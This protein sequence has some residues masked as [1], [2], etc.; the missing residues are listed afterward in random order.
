[1]SISSTGDLQ[2][3]THTSLAQNAQSITA[4]EDGGWVVTWQ[5]ANQ[6][7]SD[8]GVYMQAFNADGS[9][10]GDETL[11]NTVTQG[12]QYSPKITT[13]SDGGWVIVWHNGSGLTQQRFDSDGDAVGASSI[14]ASTY[15]NSFQ[16]AALPG[17]GWVVVMQ[18]STDGSGTSVNQSVFDENGDLQ[19][20]PELVN[21]YTI[22]GQFNPS[23]T[24][25]SDG[26][27]VVTWLSSD[28]EGSD[29]ETYQ[30]A[31]NPNGSKQGVETRVNSYVIGHQSAHRVVALDN[32][33]W[34]TTW[35]SAGQDGSSGGVYQQ[36]FNSDGSPNGA[37]ERVNTS[38]LY[39]QY[40]A[41]ICA[42]QDGGWV[43][44]W[45]DDYNYEI[46][47][48]AYAANGQPVG[49]ETHVNTSTQSEQSNA[50]VTALEDGGWVVVW[51]S[52]HAG[53]E[54]YQQAYHAD[55]TE[56]GAETLINTFTANDQSDPKVVA[57]SD[58]GWV[59]TWTS[60]GQDGSSTGVFQKVFNSVTN[61]APEGTD[62]TVTINEDGSH[63]FS[64]AD[65]GFTD[66]NG[67]GLRSIIISNLPENG[68]LKL[69]G[70]D[71]TDDQEIAYADISK[72]VWTPVA[73]AEGAGLASL[74]FQVVDNGGTSGGG[75][76]ADQSANTITFNVT[77]V[78]D[79]PVSAITIG[80]QTATEDT[81][82]TLTLDA[83]TFTDVDAGDT[84]TYQAHWLEDGYYQTQLPSWLQFDSVTRTFSGTPL[85]YDAG[86]IIVRVRATDGSGA[87]TY[88]DFTLTV[89]GVNDAPTV[90]QPISE[91]TAAEDNYFVL[92]SL[93]EY[94]RDEETYYGSLSLSA[95]LAN[96]DSLPS[97]L[98]FNGSHL[99]GT[100]PADAVGTYSI[101]ITA[102][103]PGGKS[104]T[105]TFTLDVG[106]T[107]DAPS[108]QDKILTIIESSTYTFEVADFGFSDI[109]NNAFQAIQITSYPNYGTLMLDGETVSYGA[110]I[111]VSDF[112]K[113]VWH[114]DANSFGDSLTAFGFKVIDDGGT[115][116]GGVN[117]DQSTNWI[118]F[119]VAGTPDAPTLSARGVLLAEDQAYTFSPSDFSGFNDVDGDGKGFITF[120]DIP[121]D[122]RLLLFGQKVQE[123]QQIAAT[124]N[125][126]S[127]LKWY[128]KPDTTGDAA[129]VLKFT[130]SDN[131][132]SALVSNEASMAFYYSN[133]EDAPYARND[134]LTINEG[135]VLIDVLANDT[136]GDGD[137]LAIAN[138]EVFSGDA[139]VVIEDG[140]IKLT[141]TGRDLDAGEKQTVIV[142]YEV[143][144]GSRFDTALAVI[145]VNGIREDGDDIGGTSVAEILTGSDV[146]EFIFAL[147]GN[148]TIIG[149]DGDDVI[150][151]GIG[152]D[153][154]SGGEGA[155]TFYFGK[156]SGK[157]IILDFGFDSEI[158]VIDL[159][160]IKQ[161][162]SYKDLTKNHLAFKNGDAIITIDK[163]NTIT[164]DDVVKTDLSDDNFL[165]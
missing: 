159:S 24:V 140:D 27:W 136:D 54:F 165:F 56:H 164:L 49:S 69:D 126:M 88:Q 115:A 76:N 8:L 70:I 87:S 39:S 89:G 4:L 125:N 63:T 57:L 30:Q 155:D 147:G 109:E 15:Y 121:S 31:Y 48:Q 118:S 23:V 120:T 46:Y 43:I 3:N 96:G 93:S 28:Q 25:L 92:Y 150:D 84:L 128:A 139:S 160:D 33:G 103:D 138:A 64:A 13:L 117:K 131:S 19:G 98:T 127:N 148:D 72:L 94:F 152:N 133:V 107:N 104:I 73:N 80:S 134:K 144:D 35:V 26:G 41:S 130:I 146:E 112:A 157:D 61:V 11:V 38:T 78:N 161:I 105:Q 71:V 156:K 75:I 119:D 52:Y 91:Q 111:S 22:S 114:A 83:G 81:A 9:E 5:S 51:R 18:S 82:F 34:V 99:Y 68:T 123:G 162:T 149:N 16:V 86:S 67:D 85:N 50:T 42:L 74:Q 142:S 7:G 62:N 1:M 37:E 132:T 113:L 158:D 110:I 95:E 36:L 32:G 153:V 47:Q 135:T 108:G 122:G 29:T 137:T 141:W 12:A 154:M 116:H 90:Y 58:G 40:E 55:G 21:T 44:T 6:D 77:A 97:W 20:G 53:S 129:T 60:T 45:T 17:G 102:T 106:S 10:R 79:T 100:P 101:K 163:K 59:V 145:T 143:T 14:A 65:F 124:S 66:S 2:V 151:G